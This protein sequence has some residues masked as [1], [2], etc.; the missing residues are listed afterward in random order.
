[1]GPVHDTVLFHPWAADGLGIRPSPRYTGPDIIRNPLGL[2]VYIRIPDADFIH[3]RS[4]LKRI[5]FFSGF[6][7]SSTPLIVSSKN[8]VVRIYWLGVLNWAWVLKPA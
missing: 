5:R 2:N 7:F 3:S 1:M 6:G 8:D 4:G